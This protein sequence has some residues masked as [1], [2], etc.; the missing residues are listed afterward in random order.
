VQ[1]EEEG[2]PAPARVAKPSGG[3]IGPRKQYE[4]AT[5]KSS[6]RTAAAEPEAPLKR[7]CPRH[8]ETNAE[9]TDDRTSRIGRAATAAKAEQAQ[10]KYEEIYRDKVR[11]YNDA[12]YE[13]AAIE[14][15]KIM[16]MVYEQCVE[17]VTDMMAI[18]KQDVQNANKLDLKSV[19][20]VYVSTHDDNTA[21]ALAALLRTLA[22]GKEFTD[23][24][25]IIAIG[26][27]I[28]AKKL[29]RHFNE[30]MEQ[31]ILPHSARGQHAKVLSWLDDKSIRMCCV[32]WLDRKKA[33]KIKHPKKWFLLP[34]RVYRPFS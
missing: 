24:V 11:E 9:P 29:T 27:D 17:D 5:R 33:F 18:R 31:G 3:Q 28:S 34:L 13:A 25:T 21:R 16:A 8:A 20:K 26:H 30:Y 1:V 10:R 4:E 32:S 22:A 19:D 15:R 7:S 12:A 23:T 14:E 2:A 6:R